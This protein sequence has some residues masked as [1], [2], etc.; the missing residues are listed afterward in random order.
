MPNDG[1]NKVRLADGSERPQEEHTVDLRGTINVQSAA[2]REVDRR[3]NILH[4]HIEEIG[5]PLDTV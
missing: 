5:Q 1:D 3:I 4:D 2:K